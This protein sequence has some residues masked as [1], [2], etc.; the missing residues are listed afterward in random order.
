MSDDLDPYYYSRDHDAG[1]GC[2]C[3]RGPD[4]FRLVV[5]GLDK[6][7]AAIIGKLLSERFAD[8]LPMVEVLVGLGVGKR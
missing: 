3:V 1:P 4:G 5:P 6:T 7:V 2:W 8:A